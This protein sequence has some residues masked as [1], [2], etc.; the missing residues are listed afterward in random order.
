MLHRMDARKKMAEF[1]VGD[2]VMHKE[3]GR[4]IIRAIDNE[5]VNIEFDGES[6][7]L[8][9]EVLLKNKLLD[10]CKPE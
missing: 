5:L 10:K 6:K 4:G 2:M 7:Q 3:L 1:S 9:F 8:N